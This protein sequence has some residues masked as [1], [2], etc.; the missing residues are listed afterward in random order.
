MGGSLGKKWGQLPGCLICRE[1]GGND[2]L[3]TAV[4]DRSVYHEVT[5]RK[6]VEAACAGYSRT[7]VW[8]WSTSHL[9]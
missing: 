4:P 3:R 5:R 9:P 6:S 8:V 1:F 7:S 2:S